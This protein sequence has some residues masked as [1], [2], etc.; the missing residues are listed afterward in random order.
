MQITH[1]R[2]G[3][4]EMSNSW[5]RA[6]EQKGLKRNVRQPSCNF[7]QGSK[8]VY[9]HSNGIPRSKVSRRTCLWLFLQPTL[10]K[11]WE[12]EAT[13]SSVLI[14]LG[15]FWS[16]RTCWWVHTLQVLAPRRTRAWCLLCKGLLLF[17]TNTELPVRNTLTPSSAQ[18]NLATWHGVAA[19]TPSITLCSLCQLNTGS[20][21]CCT[22]LLWCCNQVGDFA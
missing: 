20:P 12:M 8:S 17:P 13:C 6:L 21:D 3:D 4:Y 19:S 18:F 22:F 16:W 7:L 14:L 2:G 15:E 10:S 1:N 9:P 11:R 5:V